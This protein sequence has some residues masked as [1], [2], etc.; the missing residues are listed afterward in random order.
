MTSFDHNCNSKDSII[1]D[2]K[3]CDCNV[4]VPSAF[5]PNGDGMNDLFRPLNANKC[6]VDKIDLNVFNRW[7]DLMFHS[8]DIQNPW[9]G[10]FKG[11]P[12]PIG[13]YLWTLEYSVH[14]ENAQVSS[15]SMTGSVTLL[16]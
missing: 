1:V 5:T 8:E 12:L 10:T 9:D 2:I 6:R 11:D 3:Y 13:V 4:V 15:G 14:G 7:G 16:R